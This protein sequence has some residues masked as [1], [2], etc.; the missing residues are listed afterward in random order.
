M[1]LSVNDMLIKALAV[2]LIEVPSCNVMLAGDQLI[3]F[4]RADISVAVSI[5][6]GL[7]TPI[8]TGADTKSLVGHRHRDQGSRRAAPRTAS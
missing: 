4:Q 2:A 5:P 8:V 1:K 7:I 6:D 3:T